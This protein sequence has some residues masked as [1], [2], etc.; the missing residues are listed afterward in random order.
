MNSNKKMCRLVAGLVIAVGAVATTGLAAL[1]AR[2]ESLEAIV[3][4]LAGGGNGG[5]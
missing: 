5:E 1:H 4:K 2:L 3:A